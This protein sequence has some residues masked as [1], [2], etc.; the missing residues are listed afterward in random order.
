MLVL[1]PTANI[2]PLQVYVRHRSRLLSPPLCSGRQELQ[3]FHLDFMCVS[4]SHTLM[5]TKLTHPADVR[6]REDTDD[7][8]Y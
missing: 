7:V 5:R 1:L 2:D 6:V 3:Q 4:H 8:K